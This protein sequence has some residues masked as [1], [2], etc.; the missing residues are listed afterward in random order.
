[1]HDDIVLQW[2]KRHFLFHHCGCTAHYRPLESQPLTVLWIRVKVPCKPRRTELYLPRR[3]EWLWWQTQVFKCAQCLS[4]D[5]WRDPCCFKTKHLRIYKQCCPQC[6]C[7]NLHCV[8]VFSCV[9]VCVHLLCHK[10]SKSKR[11]CLC[12]IQYLIMSVPYVR[13]GVSVWTASICTVMC[14]F[15]HSRGVLEYYVTGDVA[16]H[17]N[18]STCISPPCKQQCT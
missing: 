12:V 5:P 6:E 14:W 4:A 16:I 2:E 7:V 3:N 9:L 11:A 10:Y 18:K 17:T 15:E 1:M 13:A 8:A